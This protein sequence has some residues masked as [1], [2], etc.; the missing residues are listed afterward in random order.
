[1]KKTPIQLVAVLIAIVF[2]AGVTHAYIAPTGAAGT[3][4]TDGPLTAT[5]VDEAK[6][7][8]LGVGTFLAQKNSLFQQNTYLDASIRGGTPTSSANV[9]VKFGDST[10]KVDTAFTGTIGISGFYQSDTLKTGG[11]KKPLC[12]NSTGTLYICGQTPPGAT[13]P[14]A[15][16]LTINFASS[17]TTIA[18]RLSQSIEKDVTV[19]V[20]AKKGNGGSG[21]M[22]YLKNFYTA[23][24]Y[25]T[26]GVCSLGTNYTALQTLTIYAGTVS[27]NEIG[28]P[29]GCDSSNTN[30]AISSY[31]PT[32]SEKGPIDNG[33][34]PDGLAQ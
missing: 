19:H 10:Y 24:A 16:L 2:L 14:Q 23:E 12:A 31:S 18:A 15:I 17:N 21:L 33:S 34:A 30:I 9:P 27:S 28:L 7:G 1:M 8:G 4:N 11:G 32:V 5:S 25:V 20:M 3:T 26:P 22:T 6:A 29:P 13:Q